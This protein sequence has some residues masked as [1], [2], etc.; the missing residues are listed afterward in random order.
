M[1]VVRFSPDLS[2][3]NS[4]PAG[5]TF[6]IGVRV[7]PQEG[8]AARPC[9]ALSVQVS[10]DDGRTWAAPATV[11]G[12]GQVWQVRITHP[13]TPGYVS[14]RATARDTAGNTVEQTIIRAYRTTR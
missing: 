10:Y 7:Q 5:R 14:L 11:T 12:S 8:A 13:E 9:A 6:T 3:H 2:L 1:S 4:A